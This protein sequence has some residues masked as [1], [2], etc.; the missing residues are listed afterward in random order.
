LRA[1]YTVGAPFVEVDP[2]TMKAVGSDYTFSG[3]V[4]K[5]P[6][7]VG[8]EGETIPKG[9]F[10][11]EQYRGLSA[12]LCSRAEAANRPSQMGGDFQLAPNPNAAV[13]LPKGFRLRGVYFDVRAKGS[14]YKV[15]PI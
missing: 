10:Q 8:K 15:T 14:G 6:K 9:V 1:G 3:S 2:K 12:L 5:T 7:E 4:K 11:L 13:S